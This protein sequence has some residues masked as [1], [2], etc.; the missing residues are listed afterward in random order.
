MLSSPM[1]LI[2]R[3]YFESRGL[4]ESNAD[5]L[6]S[7]LETVLSAEP[8]QQK[9]P[10]HWPP[11]KGA[12]PSKWCATDDKE[13]H[14]WCMNRNPSE[15]H[16]TCNCH[17]QEATEPRQQDISPI[18]L[19][20]KHE[21]SIKEWA[22]DD[23]L[24]TTQETVEFNLRTFARTILKDATEPRQQEDKLRERLWLR[25]QQWRE[26]SAEDKSAAKS[27]REHLLRAAYQASAD[28][29]EGFANG[30]VCDLDDASLLEATEPRPPATIK[31]D[32]SNIRVLNGL[33]QIDCLRCEGTG[34][35]LDNEAATCGCLTT[36][37][38]EELSM[39]PRPPAAAVDPIQAVLDEMEH[40]GAGI[41]S[42][43]ADRVWRWAQRLRAALAAPREDQ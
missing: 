43:A 6:A 32:D 18:P 37:T 23:R 34:I 33:P 10:F 39:E 31:S 17:K 35:P 2:V 12:T 21:Q 11:T 30:L 8:R 16:C 15:C 5:T 27:E 24:W 28:M 1:R 42:S 22:A 25:V 14:G 7:E 13:S 26:Q 40:Y 3:N 20:T 4:G 38:A 19:T 36:L 9:R 41:P 29:H